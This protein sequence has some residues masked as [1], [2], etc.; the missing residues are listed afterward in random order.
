MF[1][2]LSE[3]VNH[4][5]TI[6]GPPFTNPRWTLSRNAKT[7]VPTTSHGTGRPAG[8]IDRFGELRLLGAGD[9]QLGVTTDLLP[10]GLQ[11]LQQRVHLSSTG[12]ADLLLK[13][14]L[15]VGQMETQT[16]NTKGLKDE[17]STC[18]PQVAP[19]VLLY[20]SFKHR[21]KGSYHSTR[22]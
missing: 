6:M 10:H 17:G 12:P 11:L 9:Q 1:L 2:Y 5:T 13:V 7:C 20:G 4:Q 22:R 15:F 3:N 18:Q 21:P 14:S 19:V 8:P 16:L